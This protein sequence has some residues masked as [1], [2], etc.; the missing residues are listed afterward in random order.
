[1]KELIISILWALLAYY[2]AKEVKEQ[3]PSINIE[4]TYYI[5]GGFLFGLFSMLWC[6]W[7]HFKHVRK[8]G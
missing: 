6:G 4:P 7:K 3:H 5:L 1:M 2:Y 8:H